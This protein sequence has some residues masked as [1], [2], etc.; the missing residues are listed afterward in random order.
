MFSKALSFD[1]FHSTKK[2][3]SPQR[4]ETRKNAFAL[5]MTSSATKK[6]PPRKHK[7]E[8]NFV[9]CENCSKS[10]A[11]TRIIAH[12]QQCIMKDAPRDAVEEESSRSISGH[13]KGTGE[14]V[15][16]SSSEINDC[17]ESHAHGEQFSE[18]S[19][20]SRKRQQN[21]LPD[22]CAAV[23]SKVNGTISSQQDGNTVPPKRNAFN[24]M[25][26]SSKKIFSE[27]KKQKQ[28][29][30]LSEVDGKL[31]LQWFCDKN[32]GVPSNNVAWTGNL[33]IR[34]SKEASD[35]EQSVELS[36]TSSIPSEAEFTR[37]H[38]VKQ[39]SK[40]SVP[41]LKSILQKSIRRRRPKPS[42]RLA[43]ELA[44][45][46]FGE[47]IRRLPII[48]LEDSFLHHEFPFLVWLMIAYSKV[49]L[50]FAI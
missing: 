47:L 33:I 45:K 50:N 18:K 27:K 32:D 14:I 35:N 10:F 31:D 12:R 23:D 7:G 29:F 30:H 48:C 34:A 6:S 26:K 24:H 20:H 28:T 13:M 2:M 36:V 38:Y 3:S 11:F 25:L 22:L 43:M 16:E 42:V 15:E 37:T 4:N 49:W 39:H 8:S 41:V 9:L 21:S 5:L 1:T 46:S 17:G 19:S 40:L 44:D